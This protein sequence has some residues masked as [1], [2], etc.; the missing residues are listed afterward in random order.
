MRKLHVLEQ[1]CT[2]QR[3]MQGIR[4]NDTQHLL[5]SVLEIFKR[6]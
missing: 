6:S 5:D 2:P 1:S 4:S 3:S